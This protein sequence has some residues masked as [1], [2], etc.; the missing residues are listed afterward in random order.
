MAS[1]KKKKQKKAAGSQSKIT[2]KRLTGTNR[3]R[4]FLVFFFVIICFAVLAVRLLDI[5]LVKGESYQRNVMSVMNYDGRSVPYKRGQIL[6]RS[7]SILATSEKIY[8]LVLDPYVVNNS[9]VDPKEEEQVI[10]ETIQVLAD[11]FI[12]SL[13][14]DSRLSNLEL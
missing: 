5:D 3:R 6:D 1:R 2:A 13:K 9:S 10:E 11:Y 7:G 12:G 4:L 8:S 14:C